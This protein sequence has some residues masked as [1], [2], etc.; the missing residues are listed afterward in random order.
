MPSFKNFTPEVKLEIR[1]SRENFA[2]QMEILKNQVNNPAEGFFGPKSMIWK[3][4]RDPALMLA[5]MPALLMQLAHPAI[6]D[7]VDRYSN[8]K[9]DTF[10]RAQRT[11]SAMNK[12]FF[13]DV[14]QAIKSAK[15]LNMI[16]N[17]IRGS[18]ESNK[19][20]TVETIQYCAAEPHLLLLVWATIVH[21][22]FQVME[23]VYGYR[24][25]YDWDQ[26]YEETKTMAKLFGIP[27]S[28]YPE[29]INAFKIYFKDMLAGKE[30]EVGE[31]GLEL[32]EALFSSPFNNRF[33]SHLLTVG[34]LDCK[35]SKSFRLKYD[36]LSLNR[37]ERLL[38]FFRFLFR[39]LPK[40]VL[41]APPY[42]QALC[43]VAKA[44]GIRPISLGRFY[45]WMN[46][47][48]ALPFCI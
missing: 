19:N 3:I 13:G 12:L 25:L 40:R 43:R 15:T 6:A 18:Y 47:K 5:G 22:T 26:Y 45:N 29:D 24:N 21:S 9:Q 36:E 42:H 48:V 27:L 8:F 17:M 33:I 28:I 31:T 34:F 16:H 38:S 11:F 37:S 46:Q 1:N 10:G 30:L 39:F 2:K 41:Y 4:Y 7:G 44:R 20:G 32:A 35:L 14:D 23:D